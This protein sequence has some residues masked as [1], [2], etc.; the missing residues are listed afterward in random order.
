MNDHDQGAAR[1]GSRWRSSNIIA[2]LDP[3]IHLRA[4]KIRRSNP[5]VTGEGWIN[6]IETRF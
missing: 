6:F 3:T 5:R 2:G 1:N 4:K